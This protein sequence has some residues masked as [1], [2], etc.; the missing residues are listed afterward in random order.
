M[1]RILKRTPHSAEYSQNSSAGATASRL[2][3]FIE[4]VTYPLKVEI[5]MQ[6]TATSSPKFLQQCWV[7][8]RIL[9]RPLS[10][11]RCDCP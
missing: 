10:G 8:P 1:D 9:E 7:R 6:P 3:D 5:T 4:L 2:G 11:D